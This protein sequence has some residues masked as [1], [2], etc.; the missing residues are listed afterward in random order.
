MA[1]NIK[2]LEQ[3]RHASLND[4]ASEVLAM[5]TSE[6]A[7]QHIVLSYKRSTGALEYDAMVYSPAMTGTPSEA[8]KVPAVLSAECA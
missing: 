1:P 2:R 7:K 6:Y 4:L 3:L 8:S 5:K